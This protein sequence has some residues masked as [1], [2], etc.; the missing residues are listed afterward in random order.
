[1]HDSGT[2]L[3]DIPRVSRYRGRTAG[4]TGGIGLITTGI[5]P[6][7]N[8]FGTNVRS[9]KGD[10]F[11]SRDIIFNLPL[12]SRYLAF[13]LISLSFGPFS[14][15]PTA[16]TSRTQRETAPRISYIRCVH[17]TALRAINLLTYAKNYAL[18]VAIM[19]SITLARLN[20]DNNGEY[21]ARLSKR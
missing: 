18:I 19:I 4:H 9:S 10:I 6:R 3:V 15:V 5:A 17:L 7:E 1:M 16:L 11:S 14:G 21:G 12:T 20:Y 2:R 13:S 8:V